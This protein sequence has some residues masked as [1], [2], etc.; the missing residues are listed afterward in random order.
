MALKLEDKKA[1]VKEVAEVA[2]TALSAVVADY[3]GLTAGEM[4]ALREQARKG[5]IYFK[6]VRNTLTRRAVENTDFTCLSGALVGP[7]FVAF[8]KDDPGAVARLLK[9]AVRENEKLVVRALAIGGKLLPPDQLEVIANLP[10]REK[11]LALLLS[12]M[13]APLTQLVRTM[14]EPCAM[15]AR[16]V[17]AVGKSKAA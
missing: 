16:T 4:T 1:M 10:T 12:A 17:V 2:A 6:V 15:L 8:A 9:D 11:A 5:G 7:V 13:K 14:V 3:R